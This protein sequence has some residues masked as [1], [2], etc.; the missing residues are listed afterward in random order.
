MKSVESLESD[1]PKELN[2]RFDPQSFTFKAFDEE[3]EA[4][5]RS[6]MEKI[7][8]NKTPLIQG[9]LSLTNAFLNNQETQRNDRDRE[10][11]IQN[12]YGT[13][14]IWD[15]N[16]MY[17][18]N[19]SGGSQFQPIIK[20]EK[21]A[22]VRTMLEASAP[23]NVEKGE[24]IILPDGTTELI[25]GKKHK[26][27]G[28]NTILPEGSIIYSNKLKPMG[29]TKTFAQ[30]AKDLDFNKYLEILKNPFSD[31][32]TIN[33]AT[34]MIDR[35][36]KKLATLFQDQQMMNGDSSGEPMMMKGGYTEY[37]D[38]GDVNPPIKPYYPT[39]TSNDSLA[40]YNNA[41]LVDKFYKDNNYIVGANKYEKKRDLFKNLEEDRKNF[42]ALSSDPK[43]KYKLED[44]YKNI[45]DYQFNQRESQMGFL[46]LDAPMPLY[47]TRIK[48]TTV[49]TYESLDSIAYD[50]AIEER[51]S[52]EYEEIN[53]IRQ[54]KNL[55]KVQKDKLIEDI[56]LAS[57]QYYEEV[58]K[59]YPKSDWASIY[60]YDPI[61]VKPDAMLTPE[62]RKLREQRYG[63]P[64]VSTVKPAKSSSTSSTK[65]TSIVQPNTLTPT[66]MPIETTP[67]PKVERKVVSVTPE[68]VKPGFKTT[69]GK[70][71]GSGTAGGRIYKVK[72]DN[73]ETEILNEFEYRSRGLKMEYGGYIE[74]E[75][76]GMIKRA[77]GSYS[78]RG[79]WDNIRDNKGSG[80]EP[81]AEMLK[82]E[83]KI[84]NKMEYGGKIKTIMEN[85]GIVEG[86]ELE[87]TKEEIKFLK[88]QGFKFDIL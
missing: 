42:N 12:I 84:K 57:T 59:K 87:L 38:G 23:I 14:P 47:D 67:A 53:K 80:K 74:Y 33:T 51:A 73:G 34:K 40:L 81:T 24:F 22:K 27:G 9:S 61:A 55:T 35:N 68:Q 13:T 39:P 32:A 77:D 4:V 75:K 58:D 37:E 69:S 48:P 72:Y 28:V 70:Q 8:D 45:N 17:G 85:G 71:I 44:F 60:G 36:K 7:Q 62:E 52:K 65:Q 76:G 54:N 83:R 78:K 15:Y 30:K 16:E 66:V 31:P 5:E 82:Q 49:K 20:A 6:F 46:N 1:D 64:K 88:K 56:N 50:K 26:D 3:G 19:T 2:Y 79:L 25:R 18:D 11:V 63:K 10:G 29:D 41:I 21:G 86:Q 43:Y